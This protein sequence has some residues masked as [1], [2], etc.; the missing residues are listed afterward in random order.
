MDAV[1]RSEQASQDP[2]S[3]SSLPPEVVA[4]IVQLA[5]PPSKVDDKTGARTKTLLALCL[6]CKATLESARELLL[7]EASVSTARLAKYIAAFRV[8][9]SQPKSE[10]LEIVDDLATY[11]TDLEAAEASTL[12]L[13]DSALS[14]LP[15]S[16]AGAL[17][18]SIL[19][20]LAM[21]DCLLYVDTR[22]FL[23]PQAMPN[24][25]TLALNGN[26]MRSDE[27][28]TILHWDRS[29]I[30]F[31]PQL[32]AVSFGNVIPPLALSGV[33][34][35]VDVWH[36]QDSFLRPALSP[37][38]SSLQVL[39][40]IGWI[41]GKRLNQVLDFLSSFSSSSLS[42]VHLVNLEHEAGGCRHRL[43]TLERQMGIKIIFDEPVD[44]HNDAL[45]W[46]FLD[47]VQKRLGLSV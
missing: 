21:R 45:L 39:R 14:R 26:I 36:A 11:L 23:T 24:L 20:R 28:R 35:V 37:V 13:Q 9:S 16:L 34:K 18:F 15:T 25:R 12:V 3:F 7:A 46:P 44:P 27:Q 47:D 17:S 19:L 22:T 42:K 33:I 40:I 1:D 10:F 30:P 4:E 41:P 31:L 43:A 38:T 32:K 8:T 6:T 2:A 29:N 5:I